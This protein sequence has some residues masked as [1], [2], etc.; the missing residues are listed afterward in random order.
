M[1]SA[2]KGRLNFLSPNSES[3]YFKKGSKGRDIH[4]E[5]V[6]KQRV[7]I[8]LVDVHEKLLQLLYAATVNDTVVYYCGIILRLY[9]L[10]FSVL[11]LTQL[12]PLAVFSLK[13]LNK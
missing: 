10:G 8:P 13:S 7:S 4:G 5:S 3:D 12:S 9:L 11:E 6:L 1:P 2:M